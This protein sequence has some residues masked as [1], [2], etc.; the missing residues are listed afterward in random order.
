MIGQIAAQMR[1]G[2]LFPDKGHRA[3]DA[4]ERALAFNAYSGIT[5]P[6]QFAQRVTIEL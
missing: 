2:F 5:D 4:I 6:S 1:L 3:A